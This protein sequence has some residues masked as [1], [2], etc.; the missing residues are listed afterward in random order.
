MSKYD[1]AGWHLIHTDGTGALVTG[2][3]GVTLT[4]DNVTG[5]WKL[6]A[7][8]NTTD[9]NAYARIA[10]DYPLTANNWTAGDATNL[11]ANTVYWVKT[12]VIEASTAEIK[13]TTKFYSNPVNSD[14]GPTGINGL[15]TDGWTEVWI[16]N[17]NHVIGATDWNIA[18]YNTSQTWSAPNIHK[19][20][21]GSTQFSTLYYNPN[22][23]STFNQPGAGTTVTS[24]TVSSGI[25]ESSNSRICMQFPGEVTLSVVG[26]YDINGNEITD[27]V[28][29][30]VDNP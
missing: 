23:I 18:G 24:M 9:A 13:I 30:T 27:K 17:P 14:H 21:I 25:P 20:W 4:S 11:E 22:A 26:M 12:G 1:T 15:Y 8:A 29:I 5:I 7:D 6:T 16:E 2:Q 28:S 3:D 19:N 10:N